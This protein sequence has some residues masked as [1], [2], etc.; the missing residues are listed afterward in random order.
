MALLAAVGTEDPT[1]SHSDTYTDLLSTATNI[2]YANTNE[3]A[4]ADEI[5]DDLQT[6]MSTIAA[7]AL[8]HLGLPNTTNL[9][10]IYEFDT[11]IINNPFDSDDD[12]SVAVSTAS[13]HYNMPVPDDVAYFDDDWTNL[14]DYDAGFADFNEEEEY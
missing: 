9:T 6:M 3:C 2:L 12:A 11:E 5:L 1:Q 14:S 4:S 8:T 13:D 7:D 10:A